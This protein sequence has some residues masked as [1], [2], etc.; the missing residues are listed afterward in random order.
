MKLITDQVK[1]WTHAKWISEA[2]GTVL[3]LEAL[4]RLRS[5]PSSSQNAGGAGVRWNTRR[6][7]GAPVESQASL[8]YGTPIGNSLPHI[9]LA[10]AKLQ[11][12]C[13]N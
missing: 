7:S 1:L 9:M 2:Q 13:F 6:S 8:A 10:E 11:H 4:Q 12:H 3:T 5:A